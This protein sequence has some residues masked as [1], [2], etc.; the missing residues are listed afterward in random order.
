MARR[1]LGLVQR[2]DAFTPERTANAG[3][4]RDSSFLTEN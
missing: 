2:T 3:D 1:V 4:D